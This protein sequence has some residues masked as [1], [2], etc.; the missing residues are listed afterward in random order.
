MNPLPGTSPCPGQR[1]PLSSVL[2]QDRA[3]DQLMQAGIHGV[4][5][6]DDRLAEESRRKTRSQVYLY[7]Q[8]SYPLL[9]PAGQGSPRLIPFL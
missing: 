6:N 5:V 7:F 8:V 4:D 3:E 2:P 1:V 9:V